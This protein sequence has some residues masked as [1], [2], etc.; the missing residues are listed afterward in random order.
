M[1][2]AT[3]CIYSMC[4]WIVSKFL[5]IVDLTGIT[6]KVTIAGLSYLSLTGPALCRGCRAQGYPCCI[7]LIA[8]IVM[9]SIIANSAAPTG[10]HH[11]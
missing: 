7:I 2:T 9:D 11:G 8:R 5:P 3:D 6:E 4:W 10:V 1:A